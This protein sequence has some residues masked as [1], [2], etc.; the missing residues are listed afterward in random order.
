MS[1]STDHT[2]RLLDQDEDPFVGVEL[3]EDP[4]GFGTNI[5]VHGHDIDSLSEVKAVRLT[6]S[7]SNLLA[8][9]DVLDETIE[10][11]QSKEQPTLSESATSEA[12]PRP[13]AYQT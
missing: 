2:F 1:F 6:M 4:E 3:S 10:Y 9:R 11:V 8:L 7:L 12:C 5:V 13:K